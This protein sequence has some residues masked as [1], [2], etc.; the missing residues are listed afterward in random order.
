M[1]IVISALACLR[2]TC[3]MRCCAVFFMGN[4]LS[5]PARPAH[6]IYKDKSTFAAHRALVVALASGEH[7]RVAFYAKL[8]TMEIS[9]SGSTL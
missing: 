8:V 3:A 2:G 4:S 7:G 6:P 5:L 1:P 9:P